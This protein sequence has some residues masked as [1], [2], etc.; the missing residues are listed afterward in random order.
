MCA[1]KD[2]ST[3]NLWNNFYLISKTLTHPRAYKWLNFFR[4]YFSVHQ[5]FYTLTFLFFNVRHQGGY[6]RLTA[7]SFIKKRLMVD[8]G[9]STH[10]CQCV[11]KQPLYPLTSLHCAG[12]IYLCVHT[13]LSPATNAMDCYLSAIC[14]WFTKKDC[15]GLSVSLRY[16]QIRALGSLFKHLGPGALERPPSFFA[17][18]GEEMVE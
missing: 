6:L 18:K 2:L 11:R 5:N 15:Q 10:Q 7:Q 17:T 9:Q 14:S 8:S 16:A 12:Y 1:A 3:I 13:L 4:R